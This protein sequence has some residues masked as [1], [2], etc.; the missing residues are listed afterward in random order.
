[1]DRG[2]SARRSLVYTVGTHHADQTAAAKTEN[3]YGRG[4]SQAWSSPPRGAQ[5]M[6]ML[7]V[8]HLPKLTMAFQSFSLRDDLGRVRRVKGW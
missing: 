6:I 4:P 8:H 2:R 1:L 7:G 5:V 3:P